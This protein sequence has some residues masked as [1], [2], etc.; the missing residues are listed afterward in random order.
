MR[1]SDWSSDVCSSDL[2]R[3]E[4]LV[5]DEP[6]GDRT[7]HAGEGAEHQQESRL[8]KREAARL[9]EVE[10]APAVDR[11]TRD[12]GERARDRE[13]PDGGDLEDRKLHRQH[14]ERARFGCG[15]SAVM[16]VAT[17]GHLWPATRPGPG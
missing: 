7:G 11:V 1:I 14:A 6:E 17:L 3:V 12:I 2:A 5:R 16:T 10:H 4:H 9:L 13:Y 15:R 8:R